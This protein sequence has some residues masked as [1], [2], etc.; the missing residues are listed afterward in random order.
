MNKPH[1]LTVDGVIRHPK[2]NDLLKYK[3]KLYLTNYGKYSLQLADSI[4]YCRSVLVT[5]I[6]PGIYQP[7]WLFPLLVVP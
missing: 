1:I 7:D 3:G 5:D 6:F 4:W 2:T